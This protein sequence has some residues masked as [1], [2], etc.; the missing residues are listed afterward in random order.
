MV[1]VGMVWVLVVVRVVISSSL[2]WWA[3]EMVVAPYTGWLGLVGSALLLMMVEV[4]DFP[5]LQCSGEWCEM[6]IPV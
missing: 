6:L 3:G 4:M 1:V 5:F 2:Q